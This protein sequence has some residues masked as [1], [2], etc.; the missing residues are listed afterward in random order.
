MRSLLLAVSL[1]FIVFQTQAQQPKSLPE[2]RT[3]HIAVGTADYDGTVAWYSKMLDMK[4]IQEWEDT[5]AGIKFCYLEAPD[6]FRLEVIAASQTFTKPKRPNGRLDHLYSK[7]Y[8]QFAFVTEDVDAMMQRLEERGAYIFRE[9]KDIMVIKRRIG[10]VLD[11]NGNLVE[12][13]ELME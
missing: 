6:G 7:G 12:L 5:A 10:M 3:D 13:I 1:F 9:A 8:T 2:F 11:N 4:L